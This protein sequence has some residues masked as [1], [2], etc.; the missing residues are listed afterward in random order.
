MSSSRIRYKGRISSMP[1]KF[2]LWSFGIMVCTWPPYSIPIRTVSITSSKDDRVRFCYNPTLLPYC[3][4]VLYAFLHR[5]S[6]EISRCC[7]RTRKCPIQTRLADNEPFVFRQLCMIFIKHFLRYIHCTINMSA[8]ERIFITHIYQ[9]I[10]VFS[11]WTVISL[12]IIKRSFYTLT[13]T[14]YH[15]IFTMSIWIDILRENSNYLNF[16]RNLW[17]K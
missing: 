7:T 9:H 2:V 15:K 11:S 13:R 10:T 14:V 8:A 1:S 4:D 5:C 17:I 12:F 3:T 6:K 16:N